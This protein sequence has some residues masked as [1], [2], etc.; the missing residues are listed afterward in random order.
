MQFAF[1]KKRLI[2]GQDCNKIANRIEMVCEL[3]IPSCTMY[4]IIF[5]HII[6]RIHSMH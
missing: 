1:S 5:N 6:L 2:V 4:I 3:S